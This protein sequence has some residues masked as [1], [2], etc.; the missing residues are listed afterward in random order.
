M[1]ARFPPVR[2][3]LFR[4]TETAGEDKTSIKVRFVQIYG[5]C[6]QP[7]SSILEV[8]SIWGDLFLALCICHMSRFLDLSTS[9]MVRRFIEL[10]K[11]LWCLGTTISK[12]S[13]LVL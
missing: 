11:C 5:F 2:F 6:R 9:A 12:R 7:C 8:D 1:R 10:A 3:N 4:L 13:R